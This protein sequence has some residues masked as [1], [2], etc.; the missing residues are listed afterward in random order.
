LK[1]AAIPFQLNANDKNCI[2][3][4]NIK[5]E[6]RNNIANQHSNTTWLQKPKQPLSCVYKLH[7]NLQ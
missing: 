5:V 2:F 4:K 6:D 7:T 3:V 1:Y